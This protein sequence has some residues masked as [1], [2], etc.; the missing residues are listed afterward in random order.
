[1]IKLNPKLSQ[2][3]SYTLLCFAAILAIAPV[4]LIVF[5]IVKNGASAIS[6]EFL[7]S[8]PK[9]GMRGGGILPAILGT[10]SIVL[11]AIMVTLPVGV[12]AA[13]YLNEYAKDNMLTRIIKL[14]IVNL[15]GVPSVVYGLFGFGIFV[16]FLKLGVSIIAGALTLSIM[17][18]PVIITTARSALN[19]V[20]YSFREASLSLGVSRWRTIRH[21][22]LPNAIPGILTGAIL[23]IARISGE[24]A[25]ILFTASAFYA[26]HLPHSIFD[27]V[28]ALPYH[29]YIISTQIPNM[30]KNI[31]YGTALV[32]LMMVLTM[33]CV[34]IFARIYFRKRRKW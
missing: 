21:V 12:C 30:P 22:V 3:F 26:P 20:P 27:Q 33:S 18:L 24:T 25:P 23:S 29:L 15:A 17:E 31:I 19:S 28:M 2:K 32:L 6:W 34:A 7:S 9:D 11:C 4:L 10:L 16:M 14:A 1:M 5:M 13:I 8:M